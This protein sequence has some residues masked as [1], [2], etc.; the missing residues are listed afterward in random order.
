MRGPPARRPSGSQ[1]FRIPDPGSRIAMLDIRR[2]TGVLLLVII[3]AQLFLISAQVQTKSGVPVFQAVTFGTFARVQGGTSGVLH[4]FGNIWGS[5]V[6]LRGVRAEN[7]QLKR[8]VTELSV[9]LQEQ[10]ALAQRAARLQ[11]L[12]SLQ[13]STSLPTLSAEVIAGNP[14]PGMLTVTIGKGSAD[15]VLADMAGVAPAGGGGRGIGTTPA[16]AGPARA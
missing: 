15:G 6:W 12:L 11:E 13:T 4:S 9:R 5:Y 8:Q 3:V 1:L 2:R 16:P 14:N 10:H 7:E